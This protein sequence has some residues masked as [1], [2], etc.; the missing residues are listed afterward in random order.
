[1]STEAVESGAYS[2]EVPV[3]DGVRVSMQYLTLSIEGPLGK[4]SRE[5]LHTGLKIVLEDNA[6]RVISLNRG[7]RFKARVGTVAKLIRNMME[8]VLHG[9]MVKLK[10]V[11]SHF[12]VT[13][14]YDRATGV[15]SIHNFIG[16]KSP[17]K[18]RIPYQNIDI[19]VSGQDIIVTGIDRNEV[20]QVAAMFEQA[21]K[22]KDKD[23]RIYIDGIYIFEKGP[24][25][26]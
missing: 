20:T 18:F 24:W 26:K 11:Y 5:F 7:R 12:P 21:T 19:Q 13:V 6:I 9:Y 23:Q 3:L 15:V 14:K 2:M 8:D 1:M 25:R 10:I 4:I 22:I 17:R 16:E